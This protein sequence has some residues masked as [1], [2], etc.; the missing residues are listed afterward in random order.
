MS[1]EG[2]LPA[3]RGQLDKAV[4]RLCDPQ[5]RIAQGRLVV[6]PS[7][8]R[9]LRDDLSGKQG[10]SKATAKSMPPI[11]IDDAQLL[12]TIDRTTRTWNPQPGSTPELLRELADRPW[13]PQDVE[14]L[15]TIAGTVLRWCDQIGALLNPQSV[16]D[17]VAPCPACGK[18]HVYRRDAGG[19]MV[20]AAA[21]QVVAL[22]G[23]TCQACGAHWGP[24]LY[25]HLCR[26]L[27]FAMPEGVLE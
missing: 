26:V 1:D 6:G 10:N 2:N 19:E 16:K 14:Q 3:A 11:W 4:T 12:I 20:R 7:L 15:T 22:Q 27:G 24:Q 18:R 8:Y 13:R 25:I 17:I 9:Q 23:C 21:L 5:R